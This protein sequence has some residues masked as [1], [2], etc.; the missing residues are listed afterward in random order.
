[1]IDK[2][3]KF[4]NTKN[5]RDFLIK[6]KENLILETSD[7]GKV[8]LSNKSDSYCENYNP[9]YAIGFILEA[10]KEKQKEIIDRAF[11]LEKEHYK[12]WITEARNELDKLEGF[13][14]D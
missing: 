5:T 2:I 1:M 7:I 10:I 14:N 6:N 12:E 4:Y 3:A 13:F 8:Q 11:E 9:F